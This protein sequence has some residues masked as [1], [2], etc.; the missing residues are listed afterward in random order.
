MIS[1]PS[2]AAARKRRIFRGQRD[3]LRGFAVNGKFLGLAIFIEA[4]IV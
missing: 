2:R 1:N 4:S 3:R